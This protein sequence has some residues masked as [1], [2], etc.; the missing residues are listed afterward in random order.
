M[1]RASRGRAGGE[2]IDQPGETRALRL[3]VASVADNEIRDRRGIP[4][5]GLVVA[6]GDSLDQRPEDAS[7]QH[8]G[9]T[10]VA[11]RHLP[12]GR[13]M[14]ERLRHSHRSPE[15]LLPA[16]EPLKP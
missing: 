5:Q 9:R 16:L 11:N 7:D 2:P 3:E 6:E 13:T 1:C 14:R 10:S 12:P 15:P 4:T 8:T